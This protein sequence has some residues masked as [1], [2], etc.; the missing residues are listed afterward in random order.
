MSPGVIATF[1]AISSSSITST[2]SGTSSTRRSLRVALTTT[3]S[4]SAA[5]DASAMVMAVSVPA[6]TITTAESGR[7]PMRVATTVCGAGREP[8][9]RSSA[10]VRLRACEP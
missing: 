2:R 9:R 6:R 5:C 3:A 8:E 4:I 1:S 10:C 7:Y